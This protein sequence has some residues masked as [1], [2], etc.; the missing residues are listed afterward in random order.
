M[1]ERGAHQP[2]VTPQPIHHR[3][4][5]DDCPPEPLFE[6]ARRAAGLSQDLGLPV[7][8]SLRRPAAAVNVE[9]GGGNELRGY[10]GRMR[11]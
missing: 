7:A 9:V 8:A 1:S 5:R 11:A 2:V 4:E 10:V 6:Q 3:S